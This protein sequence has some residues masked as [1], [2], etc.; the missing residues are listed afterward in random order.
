MIGKSPCSSTARSIQQ[1]DSV[2]H[3]KSHQ[4]NEPHEAR[5]IEG[6][7]GN[8]QQEQHSHQSERGHQHDGY[9]PSEPVELSHEDQQDSSCAQS[10]YA[11]QLT[12]RSALAGVLPSHLH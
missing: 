3:D 5:H 4:Q 7:S 2:L 8:K 12:K 6:N 11:E 1:E 10:E 9:R